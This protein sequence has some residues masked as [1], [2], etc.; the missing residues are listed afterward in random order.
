[1]GRYFRRFKGSFDTTASSIWWHLRSQAFFMV[2][3]V[4]ERTDLWAVLDYL[5]SG[6]IMVDGSTGICFGDLQGLKLE[7][8]GISSSSRWTA[9][10]G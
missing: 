4:E 9:A 7:Y 8:K 5:A 1:M 2:M 6:I 10:M 3:G